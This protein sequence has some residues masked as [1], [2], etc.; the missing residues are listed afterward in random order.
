MIKNALIAILIGVMLVRILPEEHLTGAAALGMSL[1]VYLILLWLEDLWDKHRKRI[2]AHIRWCGIQAR[3][4]PRELA[5]RR[6]R[7]KKMQRQVKSL[8]ERSREQWT[9]QGQ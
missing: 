2:V 8:Q 5:G 4:W 1:V 3:E 6:G 9:R 7:R